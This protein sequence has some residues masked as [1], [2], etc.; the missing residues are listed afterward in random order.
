MENFIG[1]WL[2]I[3]KIRPGPTQLNNHSRSNSGAANGKKWKGFSSKALRSRRF[4]N[5]I[6]LKL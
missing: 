1:T 6:P 5:Q 3:S 2:Y 4:L